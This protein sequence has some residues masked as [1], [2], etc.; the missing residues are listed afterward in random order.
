MFVSALTSRVLKIF[1]I[2]VNPVA[3]SIKDRNF[4][5][6]KEVESKLRI[7]WYRCPIEPEVMRKLMQKSDAQGLFHALGHLSL[8]VLSGSI[9]WWLYSVGDVRLFLVALFVHGTMASFL[10]APHHEMCHKTVFRTKWV[11]E[12]FLQFFAFLGWNN[13]KI[14]RF[15]HHF[16]HK[17]TLHL[18]GDREE[19][20]PEHPSLRILYMLQ[21]FTFNVFGGYQ[22]KGLIPTLKAFG[23]TARG[24][25]SNPMN[26]WGKELYEGCENEAQEAV[27]WAQIV[28]VGHA[29]LAT[30]FILMHQPILIL[31]VSCP[32]FTANWWR[33]F[34]GVTMHCGLR[35]HDS[36]FRKCVRTVTLD[37]FTEFLYWHMN[38]HLE[39]HMFALVPCYNL[40]ALHKAV[41]DDMPEPRTVL[42]AWR[43]M[44]E[45]WKRQQPDPDYAYDTPV[46]E[47][48]EKKAQDSGSALTDSPE[49][50]RN[51][52]KT[53]LL[54][55]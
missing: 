33:Y 22:S 16:H 52:L 54:S 36:D 15:S 13:Y 19:V 18:D 10:S 38:W 46:P 21:I 45:T 3:K 6:M 25:L 40:A 55:S 43:E 12:L 1:G 24:N 23:R 17:Y 27:Q 47:R 14:Y 39:H 2:M 44:R 30:A 35:P 51:D 11:N 50:F 4:P 29:A 34:V 37:P 5:P 8:L 53:P 20:M 42:S 49:D 26:S 41:A 31:L 9:A 28:L 7:N 32:C 48:K